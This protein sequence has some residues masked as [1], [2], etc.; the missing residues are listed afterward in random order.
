MK[1]FSLYQQDNELELLEVEVKLLR[2]TP[3][4]EYVGMPDA[5]IKESQWRIKS[6]FRSCGFDIPAAQK[7]LVN[8]RPNH[9]RKSSRGVDLCIAIGIL[10]ESSQWRANYTLSDKVIY[11]ELSLDGS[12]LVPDDAADCVDLKSKHLS[13]LTGLDSDACVAHLDSYQVRNLKNLDELKFLPAITKEKAYQRPKLEEHYYTKDIA[14]LMAVLAHSQL[15]CLFAGPQGSGKTTIAHDIYSLT[16]IPE[17]KDFQYAQKLHKKFG[18]KLN[19]RPFIQPHHSTTLQ[20]LVG[21]GAKSSAGDISL[22]HGGILFFDEFLEFNSA[23]LEALREPV[24]SGK[25]FVSR[26]GGKKHYPASFQFLA[27]T[28]FCKCGQYS[29]GKLDRCRCRNQKLKQYLEKLSG[30]MLDRFHALCILPNFAQVK[31]ADISLQQ[32]L[33]WRKTADEFA[34]QNSSSVSRY[35]FKKEDFICDGILLEDLKDKKYLSRRREQSCYLLAR[36]FANI[37]EHKNIKLE[38]WYSAA[39]YSESNFAH[40]QTALLKDM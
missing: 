4:I 34:M 26:L 6:A 2:G 39:T 24:Q 31:T 5:L 21:G 11:G 8:L 19:W 14:E 37:R 38:D 27:T 13:L 29:P 7:V 20:S 3:G 28:N 40:L 25:I 23:C 32:I 1:L 12:I 16:K 9:F 22:A 35:E 18:L 33:Q 15:S 17:Q 30:P 36:A 10:L